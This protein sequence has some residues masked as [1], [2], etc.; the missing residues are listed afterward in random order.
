MKIKLETKNK[1]HELLLK[2]LEENASESLANKI[3]NGITVEKDGKSLISKK[4]LDGFMKYATDEAKK[5]AEKGAT[6]A[7]VEDS[8]VFGWLMHYFE[9]DGIEGTLFNPDGTPYQAPKKTTVKTTVIPTI[10]KVEK[11]PE[12]QYSLFDMLTK[13]EETVVKKVEEDDEIKTSSSLSFKGEIAKKSQPDPLFDEDTEDNEDDGDIP[14]EE[15]IKEIMAE[16]HAEEDD[17]KEELPKIGSFYYKYQEIQKKYPSAVIIYRLGDF[18]EVLGDNAKTISNSLELTLTGRDCGLKERI[19]MVGFPYHCADN[20]ILKIHKYYDLVLVENDS[21]IEFL[22]KKSTK[23][24]EESEKHWI[25]D[26]TYVDED[27][28][29]HELPKPSIEIPEFLLDVFA[30]KITAR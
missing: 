9:E 8:V 2:Y 4:D 27:G 10:R 16:L 3:N 29:L 15:E 24:V 6:S 22:P 18:Y 26:Y 13:N 23:T 11:K 30:N 7:M 20:Y 12:Q 5:L 14:S 21:K 19:P 17:I 28:V 1:Q 25:D